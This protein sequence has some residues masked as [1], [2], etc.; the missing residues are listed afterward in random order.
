M[1]FW[2]AVIGRLFTTPF[3]IA[4]LAPAYTDAI[5][6]YDGDGEI[7]WTERLQ[8]TGVLLNPFIALPYELHS[9]GEHTSESV[10][11][12]TRAVDVPWNTNRMPLELVLDGAGGRRTLPVVADA[13]GEFTVELGSVLSKQLALDL[14]GRI[15]AP[16]IGASNKV[17]VVNPLFVAALLASRGHL[18]SSAGQIDESLRR[19]ALAE[20]KKAASDWQ[21]P[22]SEAI[23]R[24]TQLFELQRMEAGITKAA[25]PPKPPKQTLA[26]L[27]A[28]GALEVHPRGS[29]FRS[30]QIT[31]KNRSAL[32]ISFRVDAG[33]FLRCNGNAQDM[34]ITVGRTVSL[35][36]RRSLRT[37][38][39]AACAEMHMASPADTDS[40]VL[41]GAA[42]PR[43]VQ[44][45]PNLDMVDMNTRQAVVWILTDDASLAAFKRFKS[46]RIGSL[47]VRR[48]IAL[49]RM[50]GVDLSDRRVCAK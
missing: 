9:E 2:T 49:C 33:T 21:C 12:E 42:N 29:G 25:R 8:L 18:L 47:E 17:D 4:F 16:A 3:A 46:P 28:N 10:R 24:W 36:P 50:A 32:P 26:E 39:A 5:P 19:S 31:W 48:A 14:Q 45:A 6:D 20:L 27:I 13:A 15:E 23:E 38:F 22:R 37:A 40:F 43:L 34:V 35:A 44:V 7:E 1:S 41:A 30:V 11:R